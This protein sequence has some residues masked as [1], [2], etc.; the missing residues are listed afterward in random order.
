MWKHLNNYQ[1]G[2][3]ISFSFFIPIHPLLVLWASYCTC[4]IIRGVNL[5]F[6]KYGGKVNLFRHNQ[7]IDWKRIFLHVFEVLIFFWKLTVTVNPNKFS[8]NT[9]FRWYTFGKFYIVKF[10]YFSERPNTVKER[11]WNIFDW[12][13]SLVSTKTIL[14]QC[15]PPYTRRAIPHRFTQF[16]GLYNT[17][18]IFICTK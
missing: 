12:K 13:I 15:H 11:F 18:I 10:N 7:L 9:I 5:W 3:K 16:F 4:N 1:T 6:Q 8:S 17:C 2:E 14:H